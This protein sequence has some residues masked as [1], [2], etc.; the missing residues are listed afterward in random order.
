MFNQITDEEF[1]REVEKALKENL[2]REQTN[3]QILV[4]IFKRSYCTI[5]Q[6]YKRCCCCTIFSVHEKYRIVYAL[7]KLKEDNCYSVMKDLGFKYESAFTRWFKNHK[8]ISPFEYKRLSF[9]YEHAE[10]LSKSVN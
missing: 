5:N 6:R 9:N 1:C 8:T 7:E 2:N 10:M 3:E 4:G